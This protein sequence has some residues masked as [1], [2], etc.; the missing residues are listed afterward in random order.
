MYSATKQHNTFAS[1]HEQVCALCKI[2]NSWYAPQ[3]LNPALTHSAAPAKSPESQNLE[4]DRM[5]GVGGGGRQTITKVTEIEARTSTYP[6]N[7]FF[8]FGRTF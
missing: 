1:N 8:G 5:I 2:T 3:N 6:V 4:K 7:I